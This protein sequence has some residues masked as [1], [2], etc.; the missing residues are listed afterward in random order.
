MII[1]DKLTMI[2]FN[3]PKLG[4]HPFSYSGKRVHKPSSIMYK[5]RCPLMLSSLQALQGTYT[6]GHLWLAAGFS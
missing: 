6:I 3:P 2:H 5:G 4:K 1:F